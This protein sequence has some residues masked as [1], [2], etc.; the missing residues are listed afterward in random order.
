[1]VSASVDATP[2]LDRVAQLKHI[3]ETYRAEQEE[4]PR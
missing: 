2:L 1:M 4:S 3:M